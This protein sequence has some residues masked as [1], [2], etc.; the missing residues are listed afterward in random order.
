MKIDNNQNYPAQLPVLI[1]D[2]LFLYPFMITPIFLNDIQ[3]I[4]ALDVAIQNETM[5]FVA[6]SKIEGG[7][8]FND[9][10]DCGVIGNIMR[11]VPLPDGRIKILFQGYAKAKII[12]PISDDPLSAL[13]DLIH[14]ESLCSTKK[15]AIIEVLK[16]K[17]KA[18]SM[19]SH[20]FPPDLLRTIEEDGDPSR[21]CDL[22]LNSIKIKK[23]QAYEFFIETNLEI[24][25][26]NLIDHLAKEIEANK[27]QKEIKNKV[28]SKIDKVNKEYF[29]KEQLK[30]IQRELGSDIQKESEV[31]EYNKKLENKKPFMYDD[32]YKEIKK[33]IQKYERI[34]QDNSEASMVQT[35]IETVLDIPFESLSK[36][37]LNLLDVTKQLNTDHYALEKPKERI[38]EYFAVKELLE[39]RKIKDKDGAKVILC[40]V[41][42]PGVGKT[43]LANSIA[44]AL[45]RELVRIA[46]GGLEDVNELRG[47]RRTY[48]GAMP[49]RIVQGLIEAKQSNPVVVLDE[50]D[51]LSRNH[52]GDPSA[53]LLEILDPEQN[54]K[55]RD[56]YLNFNIDLSKIIFV[57]TANDASLIPVA[58]KDR[59][60]FIELSSYTPQEKF[61]IAKNFLIPDEIKKHGL[62]NEEISFDKKVIELIIS[63]YTRESGVRNLRRKIAEIC[64]KC[65]K[66][67]LLDKDLHTIKIS[68]KN[69]KDFLDKKVFEIEKHEKENK[70]GQVNGLA[71]TAVGGDV[72]KIEA[73]KIKG[74]GELTLT[75]SLGDVM[76]ESAKI[77]FNLIKN[78]ID[79]NII[80]I[81]KNIIYKNDENVYN[82][83]NLHIHVPDGATPKDGPSAGITITT[84][85][86]SIFSNKKVKSNV[87]MTGEIDLMGNVLPIGG[88]KEKLIAAYKAEIKIAIIPYKNF[89]RD[90]KDIPQEVIQNMEIIGVKNLEEVL[91]IALI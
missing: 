90:L 6:P 54:T 72:L 59:M 23:H 40:L 20:Y 74:K 64:R 7:R 75:G 87:A 50:I 28:H 82:L 71:W 25:L 67:L 65:V 30:Q 68:T 56:Y 19:V 62:K 12:K 55:F 31:E 5:I 60:E 26:L 44:K 45:K 42:P 46:L 37:K 1:E 49:G 10:Y 76:K 3:N 39:K 13:V 91:K 32:A 51:K 43:S 89:E 17:A 14:Q 21:I 70:I 29:L 41:G 79:Q 8:S 66:K 4:K 9:I 16:E 52:R 33:Q 86:A 61:Q 77:S 38:E 69:I 11:K 18:L 35:Y 24:K 78:L 22:I 27:I 36:K 53:V 34:H 85:I 48:I 80:K 47:H 88:L 2:E 83:Y 84:A 73:I 81:P 57:A 58:L 63:D 15:E